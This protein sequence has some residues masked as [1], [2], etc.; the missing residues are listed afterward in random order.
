M[1]SHAV[2]HV[3]LNPYIADIYMVTKKYI[4]NV[5]LMGKTLCFIFI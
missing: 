1:T 2:L 5:Y 3:L 4:L